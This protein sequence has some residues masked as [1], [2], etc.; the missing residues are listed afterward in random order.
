MFDFFFWPC[1]IF[2]GTIGKDLKI[3]AHVR[4]FPQKIQ[5]QMIEEELRMI[6]EADPILK[7]VAA[8]LTSGTEYAAVEKYLIESEDQLTGLAQQIL[9]P[10]LIMN[11][12]A[13]LQS[14][15]VL[16]T[17]IDQVENKDALIQ[18]LKTCLQKGASTCCK[19]LEK[20][21]RFSIAAIELVQAVGIDMT[22]I[23]SPSGVSLFHL[24]GLSV[25]DTDAVLNM[26]FAVNANI[27]AQC[28][29]IEEEGNWDNTPVQ[30][31]I[32]NE[33]WTKLSC[34]TIQTIERGVTLDLTKK[35]RE[36]KDAS[37]LMAK[38]NQHRALHYFRIEQKKNPDLFIIDYTQTDHLGRTG[39]HYGCLYKNPEI[40]YIF[41][42]GG[43]DI[44]QPDKSG[45]T[46]IDYL[47]SRDSDL[48]QSTLQEV[49]I[50]ALRPY[51]ARSNDAPHAEDRP[52]VSVLDHCLSS[53]QFF[54]AVSTVI[55]H[56]SEISVD[57]MGLLF[58]NV[59]NSR[60]NLCYLLEIFIRR[61][62]DLNGSGKSG[63]TAL[64]VACRTGNAH[65][66]QWLI[67]HGAL[68]LA[69]M[70]G[71][72]PVELTKKDTVRTLFATAAKAVAEAEE[73]APAAAAT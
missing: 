73:A 7:E 26:A 8:R 4:L 68:S 40:I 45:R 63:N 64:H 14:S 32:V 17:S 37:L 3:P 69:N 54:S 5:Q 55:R 22:G 16:L 24:A 10:T 41:L 65:H 43:A 57:K 62:I 50:D 20:S 25:A 31:M 66:V 12:T 2:D 39:L 42:A 48:I 44:N 33:C 21:M 51:I 70:Q 53:T 11:A 1:R 59:A 15:V 56:K 18:L 72:K 36:G 27:N 52:T 28:V 47:V 30:D 67:Q 29:Y 19:P 9:V 58:R 49:C 46:P 71:K 35:D 13:V 6:A 60:D 34:L 38:M 61:H 23:F